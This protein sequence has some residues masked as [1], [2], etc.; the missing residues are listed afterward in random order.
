MTSNVINLPAMVLALGISASPAPV[1]P[2]SVPTDAGVYSKTASEWTE[3]EP[4][5]VNW[6]TGG[7][8]KT[9]ATAGIVKSDANAHVRGA[10]SPNRASAGCEFVVVAPEGVSV[11]EYQLLRLHQH[12]DSREFRAIT[13]GIIHASGGSDR[14]V[15]DFNHRKIASRT[16]LVTLPASMPDGEYGFLPPG[17]GG[18]RAAT[19]IGKIYSFRIADENP[20][21]RNRGSE[22]PA[23]TPSLQ[24]APQR[25]T[26][27]PT[28]L[29]DVTFTSTPADALVSISGMSLG[30]TPLV[31]KLQSRRYKVAMRLSGYAE[32]RQDI[33]VYIGTATIVNADLKREEPPA[34]VIRDRDY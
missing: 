15:L 34:E 18:S 6:K 31:C 32:W 7:V 33:T 13:G 16:Y 3:V 20:R 28:D 26:A 17:A 14:D 27:A 11:T 23:A 8:L 12:S 22:P 25:L 5:I 4:E 19:A 29:V 10:R 30:Y 9:L 1:P 24:S 2:A 21:S